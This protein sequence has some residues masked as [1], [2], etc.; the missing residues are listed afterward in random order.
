MGYVMR[1]RVQRIYDMVSANWE[2]SPIWKRTHLFMVY[3]I[4]L[5]IPTALV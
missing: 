5:V 3:S 1:G 4:K 2:T